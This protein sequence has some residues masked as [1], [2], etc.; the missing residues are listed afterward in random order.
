M[1]R[2][3]R[4]Y[5]SSV[6]ALAG[7]LLAGVAMAVLLLMVA[8]WGQRVVPVEMNEPGLRLL[9]FQAPMVVAGVLLGLVLYLAYAGSGKTI[10]LTGEGLNYAHHGRVQVIPWDLM[11][12]VKPSA[13]SSNPLASAL[14]SDGRKFVRIERVLFPDFEGLITSLEERRKARQGAK[15]VKL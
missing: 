5:T 15:K 13:S 8:G 12:V 6:Q 10:T 4:T 7:F 9:A 11:V 2:D 3:G 14:V 1:S